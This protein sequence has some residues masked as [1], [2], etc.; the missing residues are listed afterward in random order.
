MADMLHNFPQSSE[1]WCSVQ[2]GTYYAE[3]ELAKSY[4]SENLEIMFNGMKWDCCS[5]VKW[6]V[7]EEN[8]W[9]SKNLEIFN[10]TH[11]F[12]KVCLQTKIEFFSSE[13]KK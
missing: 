2:T 9:F 5:E 12:L 4:Y 11:S 10:P 6:Y 7:P 8:K 3:H 13:R 1:Y